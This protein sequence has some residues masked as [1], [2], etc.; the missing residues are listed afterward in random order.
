MTMRTALTIGTLLLA[1]P[2]A[3]QDAPDRVQFIQVVGTATVAT[4]PDRA[5]LIYWVNGEG[6]TADA[7]SA[8]LAAKNKAIGDGLRTLLGRDTEVT[9]GEVS[10]IEVR[11]PECDNGNGYNRSPRLSEGACAVIGHIATLSGAVKTPAVD[12]AATAAGLA[13]RLGARD[14]RVQG[15]ELSDR[16]SALRRATAAAVA[17]A[18]AR[19]EALATGAGVRLG[20]L[21]TL[22]DP[23]ASGDEIVVHGSLANARMAG[24]PAPPA[25]P[26][27]EIAIKP[28]PIETQARVN[29]RFAILR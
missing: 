15:F 27:V 4:P 17:D 18:R 2:V 19:A 22:S 29:A 8:A 14:A 7:A 13:A 28:R 10:V 20:D 1:A 25:P 6:K 3:A 24:P 11:A 12:K 26:P 23:N 9:A 21:L 16:A 5:R